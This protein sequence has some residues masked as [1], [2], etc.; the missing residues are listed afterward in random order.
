MVGL[1]Q[2]RSY[3]Q[4]VLIVALLAIAAA[5]WVRAG[6]ATEKAHAA[7]ARLS[8]LKLDLQEKHIQA[9][10]Q[11]RERYERRVHTI[12]EAQDAETIRRRAAEADARSLR[13]ALDRVRDHA[14]GL[15]A[16]CGAADPAPASGGTPA[17][18][19]GDLLAELSAGVAEAARE[20]AE[21]AEDAAGAGRLCERSYDALMP[22]KLGQPVTSY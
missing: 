10:T 1:S 12:Q 17:R 21:F 5:G 22:R 8:E 4:G 7:E 9:L 6:L 20:L 16:Q 18:A 13:G 14:A 3:L 2:A 19:A 11:E 15:A